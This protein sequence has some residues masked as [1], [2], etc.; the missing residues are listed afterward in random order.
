MAGHAGGWRRGHV[1]VGHAGRQQTSRSGRG[2]DTEKERPAHHL[3]LLQVTMQ[4]HLCM[5]EQAMRL[6]CPSDNVGGD[7]EHLSIVYS[8]LP[9]SHSM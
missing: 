3:F 7:S 4:V 1:M 9:G 8:Y 6:L 2:E 5:Y